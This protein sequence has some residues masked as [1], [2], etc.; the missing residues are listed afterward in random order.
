MNGIST[1]LTLWL[2]VVSAAVVA[3]GYWMLTKK[4]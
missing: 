2:L 3:V 1:T 4:R